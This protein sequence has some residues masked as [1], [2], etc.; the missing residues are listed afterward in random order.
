MKT[1]I[2]K[3]MI[4]KARDENLRQFEGDLG[5]LS[6]VINAHPKNYGESVVAVAAKVA[7]VD[8]TNSTHLHLARETLP[9]HSLVEI[10]RCMEGLDG[11]IKD[12][13]PLA[14][15]RIVDEAYD[16]GR[17]RPFS[18]ATKYCC[19]HNRM[20]Y[21][22]DGYSIIDSTVCD[23][24]RRYYEEDEEMLKE[25]NNCYNSKKYAEDGDCKGLYGILTQVIEENGLCGI[26]NVRAKLDS[27]IYMSETGRLP[28]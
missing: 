10:I 20:A 27:Y 26:E 24:L 6:D 14:V 13:S 22:G 1:I 7:V 3:E 4:E 15:E 16:K 25:V 18:F 5:L 8:V 11:L 9:L 21:N 28:G 2:T 19:Y 23:W 12:G 17:Y